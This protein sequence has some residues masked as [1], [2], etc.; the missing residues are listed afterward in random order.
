VLGDYSW[1]FGVLPDWTVHR[2][3]V[4]CGGRPGTCPEKL[5]RFEVEDSASGTCPQKLDRFE[6]EDC[7]SWTCPQKLDRFE[8]EDCASCG[9]G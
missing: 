7:A 4:R 5:D 3:D 6:V 9:P 1:A 2:G 8:V